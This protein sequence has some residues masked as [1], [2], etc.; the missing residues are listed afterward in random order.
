[1]PYV[2][3]SKESFSSGWYNGVRRARQ[4]AR[5]QLHQ[6]LYVNF[7]IS[8]AKTP[9]QYTNKLVEAIIQLWYRDPQIQENCHTLVQS[10]PKRVK[11][12]LKSKGG[13]TTY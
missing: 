8:F 9:L 3:A 6:K 12:L 11:E 7:E 10:M 4:F 2:Q 1:M 13:H 5:P